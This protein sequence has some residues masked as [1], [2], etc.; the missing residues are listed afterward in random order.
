MFYYI[1]NWIERKGLKMFNQLKV[2]S[3]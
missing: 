2:I 3:D 1:E